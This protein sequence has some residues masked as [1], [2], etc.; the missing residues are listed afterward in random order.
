V[1]VEQRGRRGII[2]GDDNLSVDEGKPF[3]GSVTIGPLSK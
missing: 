3:S 2:D 1:L